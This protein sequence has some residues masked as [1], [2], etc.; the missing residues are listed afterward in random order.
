MKKQ[1]Y[2]FA[3][4]L[5]AVA[6]ALSV[7][8]VAAQTEEQKCN[9][10]LFARSQVS[11]LPTGLTDWSGKLGVINHLFPR[12]G[13][14]AVIDVGDDT[15]HVAVVENVSVDGN[16]VLTVSI[17]ES[18][19]KSCQITRRSGTMDYLRIRGF[20]DPGYTKNSSYPQVSSVSGNSARAGQAFSLDLSGSGFDTRSVRAV[21]LG[22][23]CD[24]FNK[25]VVQTDSISNR[26]SERATVPMVL[27]QTGTYTVYL[28]NA[29]NGKSSNGVKVRVQ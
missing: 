12:V 18:N 28:F 29:N 3:S 2:F 27:N 1:N 11:K 8:T 25:C 26:S 19:F 22:G 20:F 13:A 24:S 14:V 21:V 16:G 7:S 23:W 17:V 6:F 9:C 15:G 5:V 10:V 4:L